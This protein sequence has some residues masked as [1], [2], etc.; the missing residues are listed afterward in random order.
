[1]KLR[2]GIVTENYSKFA[3]AIDSIQA[4]NGLLTPTNCRINFLTLVHSPWT[5]LG[6]IRYREE[7]INNANVSQFYPL[8][9]IL[10]AGICIWPS[11]AID[12]VAIQLPN[13][14]NCALSSNKNLNFSTILAVRCIFRVWIIVCVQCGL[15][16]SYLH[17]Q[18]GALW[19]ARALWSAFENTKKRI[20]KYYIWMKSFDSQF[21]FCVITNKSMRWLTAMKR[22]PHILESCNVICLHW[23]FEF[24][25]E[26]FKHINF[27]QSMLPHQFS[28][29]SVSVCLVPYLSIL[30]FQNSLYTLINACNHKQIRL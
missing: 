29:S 21:D 28:Y 8:L 19:D 22:T 11:T 9:T 6:R 12:A 7:A 24:L 27:R 1:M 5:V 2:G 4:R 3:S 18:T 23:L 13:S 10:H 25:M 14:R 17:N 26:I 30:Y 20:L 16:H 15:L